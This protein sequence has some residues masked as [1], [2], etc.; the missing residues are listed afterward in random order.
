MLPRASGAR[1]RR[2]PH[3]ESGRGLSAIR[4]GGSRRRRA[5][6]RLPPPD[7]VPR[8]GLELEGPLGRAE[9]APVL[10]THGGLRVNP[11]RDRE[12]A[13]RTHSREERFPEVVEV[14]V[15]RAD[16]DLAALDVA[17]ARAI[18]ELHELV[19]LAEA[20]ARTLVAGRSA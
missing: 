19:Q 1:A 7:R 13:G 12:V 8:P 15:R 9:P 16:D 14:L 2:G 11:E 5:E 3:P 6:R 4:T 20:H 17:K 10:L 18:P